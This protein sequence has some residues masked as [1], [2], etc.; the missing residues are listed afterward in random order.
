MVC[1][2]WCWCYIVRVERM[3]CNK[4]VGGEAEQ[5]VHLVLTRSARDEW[6]L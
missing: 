2:I 3:S 6:G 5:G 1:G 4:K